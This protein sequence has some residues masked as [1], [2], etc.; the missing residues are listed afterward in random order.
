[1]SSSLRR[2]PKKGRR[3]NRAVSAKPKLV[4]R[5]VY[6]LRSTGMPPGDSWLDKP[7]GEQCYKLT[8]GGAFELSERSI[9]YQAR[10]DDSARPEN[11]PLQPFGTNCGHRPRSWLRRGHIDTCHLN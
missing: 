7:T 11:R 6:L 4:G 9:T 10:R 1:M 3:T 8:S 5:R 2:G